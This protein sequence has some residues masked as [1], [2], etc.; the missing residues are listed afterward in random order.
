MAGR[1][2]NLISDQDRVETCTTRMIRR[3]QSAPFEIP[4]MLFPGDVDSKP[5]PQGFNGQ[6][7]KKTQDM[8]SRIALSPLLYPPAAS[9]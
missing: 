1:S 5:T 9:F 6:S 4:Q 8:T 2:K 3:D 7:W